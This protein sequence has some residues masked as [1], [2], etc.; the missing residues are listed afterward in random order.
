MRRTLQLSDFLHREEAEWM[1]KRRDKEET[2]PNHIKCREERPTHPKNHV[3][4]GDPL[5]LSG[6]TVDLVIMRHLLVGLD[7]AHVPVLEFLTLV[8]V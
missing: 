3:N 8:P 6:Q 1:G 7:I 2:A 5:K 4:L